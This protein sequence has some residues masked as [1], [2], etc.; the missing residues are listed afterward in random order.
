M[1]TV[2]FSKGCNDLDEMRECG[3]NPGACPGV[4]LGENLG[5]G[6]TMNFQLIRSAALGAVIL[7]AGSTG[8]L[9]QEGAQEA[10]PAANQTATRVTGWGVQCVSQSRTAPLL[11]KAE[12]QLL[13]AETNQLFVKVTVSVT[14]DGKKP[15]MVVQLPHGLHLPS[16]IKL[17]FDDS[18]PET[19]Q[20]ETCDNNACY[21][22]ISD[23]KRVIVSMKGGKNL[24]L[25]FKNM[26]RDDI[27]AVL[28]LDGFTD[29][30]KSI[31]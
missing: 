9:A 17:Q 3:Q 18:K 12:Q 31:E 10:A 8:A 16:G 7:M 19:Q 11:C 6:T 21:I 25:S 30:I 15:S 29:A 14:G 23:A 27:E 28:P 1:L 22:L 24:K 26:G 20:V 13:L 4:C 5:V 2:K